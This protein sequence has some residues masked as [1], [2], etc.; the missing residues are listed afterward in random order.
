MQ[1]VLTTARL[2][3]T[4]LAAADRARLASVFSGAGVRRYLFDNEPVSDQTLDAIVGESLRQ[5][6][7]GLGLW[8]TAHDGH[9]IGCIGLHRAPP[10]TVKIFPAFAGEIEAIVAFMEDRWGNGFA[11]EALTAALAHAA[12]TLKARRV[13]ALIDLPNEKSHALFSRCG[14]RQIGSGQGPLYTALAY[15]VVL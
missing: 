5:S 13:V 9:V 6:A 1:P 2:A 15:E 8:L 7:D 3:L 14:F 12:D 10:S 4:P 11:G